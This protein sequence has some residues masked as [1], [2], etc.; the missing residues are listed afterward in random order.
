MGLAVRDAIASP[1]N[2]VLVSADTA[3]EIAIKQA[4]GRLTFPLDQFDTMLQRMGFD[5]LPI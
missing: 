5:S 4:L 1:A 3:W 2:Q